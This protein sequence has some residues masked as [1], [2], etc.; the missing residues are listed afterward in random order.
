MRHPSFY[1]KVQNTTMPSLEAGL[2]Y[3]TCDTEDLLSYDRQNY[4]IPITI[5]RSMFPPTE[6]IKRV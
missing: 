2:L 1:K 4:D 3:R 6:R 5:F